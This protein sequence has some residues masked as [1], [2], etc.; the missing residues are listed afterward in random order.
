MNIKNL[1]TNVKLYNKGKTIANMRHIE[2]VLK[3][4]EKKNSTTIFFQGTKCDKKKKRTKHLHK[5]NYTLA[6]SF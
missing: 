5:T 3:I 1:S 6:N 2:I 4:V